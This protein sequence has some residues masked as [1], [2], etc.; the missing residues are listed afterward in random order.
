MAVDQYCDIDEVKAAIRITHDEADSLIDTAISAASRRIDQYCEDQFWSAATPSARLFRAESPYVL[1]VGSFATTTGL[2]V[3]L[4]NDDDGAFETVVPTSSYQAAPL[5]PAA[6]YPYR[7]LEF[8]G[9]TRLPVSCSRRGRVQVTARWGWSVAPPQVRQAC[10]LMA[11][12]HY[13]GKN[14]TNGVVGPPIG[15]ASGTGAEQTH[16]SN[17]SPA[18]NP[19]ASMLLVGLCQRDVLVG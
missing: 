6:G 19:V 9:G 4:D 8:F 15:S 3:E 18:L 16:L 12:D 5:A 13:R 10:L 2:V 7:R 11:L 14:F 17:S 1:H